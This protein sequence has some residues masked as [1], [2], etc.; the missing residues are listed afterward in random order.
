MLGEKDGPH[1]VHHH[2]QD[3]E[4]LQKVRVQVGPKLWRLSL[5][6]CVHVRYSSICVLHRTGPGGSRPGRRAKNKNAV[7]GKPTQR[8]KHGLLHATRT[9]E[10]NSK[11]DLYKKDRNVV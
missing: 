4:Q 6:L 11:T 3:G 1:V 5:C 7:Q 8:E 2:S 9:Q 10:Y